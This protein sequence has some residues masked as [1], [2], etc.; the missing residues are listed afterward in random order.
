[1]TAVLTLPP[2]TTDQPVG[3]LA[4]NGRFPVL[5]A[6]AARERGLPVYCV[7]VSGMCDEATLRSACTGFDTCG[8]GKVGRAIGLFRRQGVREIVMA[9]KIEKKLLFQGGRYWRYFP[10]WRGIHLLWTYA[11]RD[12]KDD[13]L[14]LAVIAEFG[15][16]NLAF[17]SALDF[18]P[19]LLVKHGF[20]T[21]RR[22][23]TAQWKDIHMGW[24]IAKEMGRL[25]IGQSVAVKD[26]AVLAVEAIEGTDLC[27]RRAGELSRGTPFTVVKVAKPQQDMRFDVPT[28]GVDSIRTMYESGARCLA[29][30]SERT[31]VLDQQQVFDLADRLGIAIVSLNSEEARLRLSA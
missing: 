21:R 4:A 14:L 9:G 18:C 5:F 23:T 2:Q 13:T 25:D 10:D 31:I 7:G 3:L 17:R 6:E 1:M 29:I 27:I 12:H 15:R 26:M 22:P 11:R 30:E 28:I 16:D 19:E 8:L 20:L 24:E